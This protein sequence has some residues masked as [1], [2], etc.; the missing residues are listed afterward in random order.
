MFDLHNQA[1]RN[2]NENATRFQEQMFRDHQQFNHGAVKAA[3]K[4]Q[5]ADDAFDRRF[6]E[7]KASADAF[8]LDFEKTKSR[9]EAFDIH[10]FSGKTWENFDQRWEEMK[11]R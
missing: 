11:R 2:H 1:V 5:I 6:N 3:A 8:H 10:D 7:M 4:A 9:I